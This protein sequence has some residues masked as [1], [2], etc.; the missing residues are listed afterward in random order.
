MRL[1]TFAAEVITNYLATDDASVL[2]AYSGKLFR[3]RFTSRIW[4][5][6]A[7]ATFNQP[8]LE[9]AFLALRLPLVNA[10]AN[11]VFFGRGSFPDLEIP[12]AARPL[13]AATNLPLSN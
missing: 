10:F 3:A 12:P 8:A 2:T 13:T 4:M 7:I 1:S 9:L 6:R 11:Q 5:R